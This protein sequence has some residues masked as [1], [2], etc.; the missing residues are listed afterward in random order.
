MEHLDR[1]LPRRI[2]LL[3]PEHRRT[4]TVTLSEPAAAPLVSIRVWVNQVAVVSLSAPLATLDMRAALTHEREDGF[5]FLLY[6]QGIHIGLTAAEAV[7]AA[8]FLDLPFPPVDME[9]A[10]EDE[11]LEWLLQEINEELGYA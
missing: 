11:Q 9:G 5:A 3:S 6:G 7:R 1:P 2:E 10:S 4:L 8:A